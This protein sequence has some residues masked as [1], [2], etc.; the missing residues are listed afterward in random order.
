VKSS[1]TINNLPGIA[2]PT[3]LLLSISADYICLIINMLISLQIM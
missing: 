1:A 2:S 3:D